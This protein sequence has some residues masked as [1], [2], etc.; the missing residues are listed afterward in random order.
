[1]GLEHLVDEIERAEARSL[2]TEDRA[3]PLHA[4]AGEYTLELMGQL[5]VFAKEITD[6]TASYT[7]IACRHILIRTDITIELL[8]KR[9]TET[10]H[11][12]G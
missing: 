11:L 9:L 4:F 5:L 3:A 1:M 12:V 8:H 2:R 7:N 10:H 6:L